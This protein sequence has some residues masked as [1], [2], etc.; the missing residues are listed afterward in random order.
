MN[1]QFLQPGTAHIGALRLRSGALLPD[2]AIAY[3]TLGTLNA[4]RDNA[5][6]LTHGFTSSHLFIGRASATSSEGTWSGL[7]RPGKAI[8]TDRFFVVS[9]NMLGS[10]FG[11]TSPA[12]IDPIT[13][14]HYG[15][16]FPDLTLSDIVEAQRLMLRQMGIERL[17]AVVGP[18]YG[19][20]QGL[21]WAIDHPQ[22]LR[23]VSMS[24]SGLHAPTDT[25]AASLSAFFATDE[26]WNDGHYYERGGIVQT[27]A[28]LRKQT[29]EDYGIDVLLMRQFPDPL[30]REQEIE[31]QAQSWARLVDPNSMLVLA[32]AMETF[33]AR[34]LL[35]RIQARVQLVLSRSDR[36]FP[37]SQAPAI[38]K[39]FEQANVRA[40]Y[41][42]LDSDYGHHAAGTDYTKWQEEL[43]RFLN[44]L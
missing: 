23:G 26:N 28:R 2:V 19:G 6:L 37:A 10:S 9:S 31:R 16:H 39:A 43:R 24:V 4:E 29:I 34:P 25:T 20:F 30:A 36:L 35:E 21:T 33:D 41:V 18:S 5:I 12:S 11:S 7:V 22:A 27:M 15:P 42:A 1:A 13:G 3:A 14:K 40:E 38:M 32:K 44:S 17:V 8:D